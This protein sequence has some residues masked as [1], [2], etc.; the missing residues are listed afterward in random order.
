MSTKDKA[1]EIVRKKFGD[2]YADKLEMTLKGTGFTSAVY[3]NFISVIKH[4]KI[5][6][7]DLTFYDSFSGLSIYWRVNGN[8][9]DLDI[10]ADYIY[11]TLEKEDDAMEVTVDNIYQKV[12]FENNKFK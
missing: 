2:K 10:S 9:I 4:V 8:Y 6:K 1:I 12:D 5:S 3:S 7:S 11:C